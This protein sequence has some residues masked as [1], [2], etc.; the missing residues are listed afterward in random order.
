MLLVLKI[1]HMYQELNPKT[2]QTNLKSVSCDCETINS[3]ARVCEEHYS[4]Y[5]NYPMETTLVTDRTSG[6]KIFKQL[7]I[8]FK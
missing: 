6:M 8:K 2:Q 1:N 7:G 3:I 4:K 5:M